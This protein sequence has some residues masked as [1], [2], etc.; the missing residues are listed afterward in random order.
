MLTYT[1]YTIRRIVASIAYSIS[2]FGLYI[3]ALKAHRKITAGRSP[4]FPDTR[5]RTATPVQD[6]ARLSIFHGG[7]INDSR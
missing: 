7:S 3:V 5:Q 2:P 1:L 6:Y 4:P